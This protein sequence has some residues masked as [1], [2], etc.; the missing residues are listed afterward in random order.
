M[1]LSFTPIYEGA[2]I[3][4]AMHGCICVGRLSTRNGAPS[5]MSHLPTEH[6]GR[7]E[8]WIKAKTDL[9]AKN[10]LIAHWRDWLRAAHLDEG[11]A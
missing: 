8:S 11:P 9:A 7:F 6:G 2:D 4:V 5:W 3:I 1:T 10:A